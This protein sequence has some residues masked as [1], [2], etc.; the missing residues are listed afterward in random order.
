MVGCG[1]DD[2]LLTMATDEGK[3]SG[4][5]PENITRLEQ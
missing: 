4:R 2:S 5:T 1:S 3:G